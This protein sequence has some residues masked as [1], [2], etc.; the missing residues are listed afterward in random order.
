MQTCGLC[1]HKQGHRVGE[2]ML[3]ERRLERRCLM[4]QR[5]EP[6]VIMRRL[7]ERP[8]LHARRSTARVFCAVGRLPP[9]RIGLARLRRP[10][11]ACTQ[12]SFC[13]YHLFILA[14]QNLPIFLSFFPSES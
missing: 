14:S 2:H 1:D 3:G 9:T 12:C 11:C 4:R 8:S 5:G 13:N 10:L 7:R 6:T